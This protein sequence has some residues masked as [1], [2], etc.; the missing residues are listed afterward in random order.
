MGAR[1]V[2]SGPGA[3]QGLALS[4][5]PGGVSATRARPSGA[6]QAPGACPRP[7]A[8][9]CSVTHGGFGTLSVHVSSTPSMLRPPR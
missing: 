8:E 1:R 9:S 6:D 4:P 5:A 2:P 7:S 3:L